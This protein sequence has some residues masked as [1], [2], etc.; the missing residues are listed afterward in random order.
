M[1]VEDN[2]TPGSERKDSLV[3]TAVVI[4]RESALLAL[5]PWAPIPLYDAQ[6]TSWYLTGS[7]LCYRRETLTVGDLNLL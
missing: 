3:R 6:S 7:E 5:I 2:E 4:A 1:V